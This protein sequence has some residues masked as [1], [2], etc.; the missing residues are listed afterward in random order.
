MTSASDTTQAPPAVSHRQIFE[1]CY[2]A[3]PQ[4]ERAQAAGTA[5]DPDLSALCFD[6]APAVIRGVLDNPRAALLHARLIAAHHANPVGLQ[7]VAARVSFAQ[8]R[9]VQRLLLRNIQTPETVV[10]SLFSGRQLTDIFRFSRSHDCPDRHR[11]TARRTLK[12]R[13]STA[14]SEERVDLIVT[15]EGRAL[16]ALSSVPLDGR[17]VALLCLRGT[18]SVLLIENLARWPAT[19]PK[20]VAHL[21]RQPAVSQY[22]SLKQS[23]LR[24]PNRPST[25]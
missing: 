14:T 8:D 12:H 7:A 5:S 21:L 20:L 11:E 13:F 3:L 10:R 6:P 16:T 2:R 19:P 17:S 24:H 1:T 15:S 25:M 18:F 23:I 9:E 22:P 4:D